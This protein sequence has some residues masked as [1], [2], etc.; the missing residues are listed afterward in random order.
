[1]TRPG[2]RERLVQA[3]IASLRDNGVSGT[4]IAEVL[5]RSGAARGSVYQHFPAGKSALVAAAVLAAG[6]HVSRLL[7]DHATAQDR[8]GALIAWWEAEVDHDARDG[9]LRGC[10]VAAA[11]VDADPVVRAAAAEVFQRWR[12]DLAAGLG[13]LPRADAER[14]ASVAISALEGAVLQAR[15]QRSTRPLRDVGDIVPPM[16]LGRPVSH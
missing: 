4:G 1:M 11:A 8:F 10:P 6:Q 3:T 13:D 14:R 7:G 16:L 12:D 9:V 5:Q 2:A 15:A